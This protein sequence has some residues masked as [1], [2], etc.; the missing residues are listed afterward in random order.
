MVGCGVKVVASD[1]IG[2]MRAIWSICI[3]YWRACSSGNIWWRSR[4]AASR[5]LSPPGN[6]DLALPRTLLSA[7]HNSSA[8]HHFRSVVIGAALHAGCCGVQ[9]RRA[10]GANQQ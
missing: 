9:A 4:A 6:D 7:V 2:A 1:Q 3:W 8:V 5:T 10:E